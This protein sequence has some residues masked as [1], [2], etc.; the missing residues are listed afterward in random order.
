MTREGLRTK[1]PTLQY[2]NVNIT[3]NKASEKWEYTTAKT[4][5][6]QLVLT[7]FLVI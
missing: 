7:D 5:V 3:T 2:R 4:F 1:N 6:Q